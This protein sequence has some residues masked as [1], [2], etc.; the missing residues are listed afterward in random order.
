MKSILFF[1]IALLFTSIHGYAA[2]V[3]NLSEL[4]QRGFA[5]MCQ[6]E[7]LGVS[8]FSVERFAG[9]SVLVRSHIHADGETYVAQSPEDQR[10]LEALGMLYLQERGV[11]SA[12]ETIARFR[13]RAEAHAKA[14]N[15]P[16]PFVMPQEPWR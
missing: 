11:Y 10:G 16:A 3:V 13:M 2:N 15:A 8:L 12:Q 1:V 4:S 9:C 7:H 14:R 6:D 5:F